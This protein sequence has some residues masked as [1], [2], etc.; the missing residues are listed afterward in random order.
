MKTVQNEIGLIFSLILFNNQFEDDLRA[1]GY[2]ER[3]ADDS[4]HPN[5]RVL[6]FKIS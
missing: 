1:N 5:P 3:S 4:F 6:Y 2:V